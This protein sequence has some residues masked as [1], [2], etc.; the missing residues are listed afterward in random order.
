[1]E[2][3]EV[4]AKKQAFLGSNPF[5]DGNYKICKHHQT[6]ATNIHR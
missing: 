4:G 5:A 1:M 2:G 3:K 6:I